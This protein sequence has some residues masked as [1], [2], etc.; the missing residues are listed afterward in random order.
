MKRKGESMS[1]EMIPSARHARYSVG[2][3]NE[4][5]EWAA[6]SSDYPSLSWLAPTPH[7][8][9][10]GLESLIADIEDDLQAEYPEEP[11]HLMEG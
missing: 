6:T 3:S 5:R 9:L 2:F 7:E 10:A 11:R 8:A 4:D 1:V